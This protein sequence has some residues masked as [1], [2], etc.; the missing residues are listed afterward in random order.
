LTHAALLPHCLTVLL[1]LVL[2]LVE[3]TTG[4]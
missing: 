1:V 4:E 3:T 2:V